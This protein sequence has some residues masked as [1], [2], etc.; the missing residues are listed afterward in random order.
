MK[1]VRKYWFLIFSGFIFGVALLFWWIES[2]ASSLVLDIFLGQYNG[3]VFPYWSLYTL[4]SL[5]YTFVI[6]IGF[7]CLAI[8][9]FRSRSL[10]SNQVFR[11]FMLILLIPALISCGWFSFLKFGIYADGIITNHLATVQVANVTYQLGAMYYIGGSDRYIL[12]LC[13]AQ[14]W[15]CRVAH[16]Q[17]H[18]SF[19]ESFRDMALTVD[20]IRQ[21]LNVIVDGESV[22]T[23]AP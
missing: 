20:P 19:D 10:K 13:D 22:Y 5:S 17:V 2:Q 18:D 16:T 21:T 4:D 3:Q 11:R 12:Y 8:V 23:T 14:G 15:L 6:P 1:P 7:L 9:G